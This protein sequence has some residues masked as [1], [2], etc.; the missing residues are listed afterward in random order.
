MRTKEF[1]LLILFSLSYLQAQ[2][3]RIPIYGAVQFEF[4]DSDYDNIIITNISSGEVSTTNII[5][6]FVIK[7]APGD[8]LEAKGVNVYKNETIVTEKHYDRKEILLLLQ[9]LVLQL[10]DLNITGFKF[11]GILEYDVRRVEIKDSLDEAIAKMGIPKG[12]PQDEYKKLTTPVIQSITSLNL[13]ALYDV[14]SGKR[15]KELALYNYKKTL[16][17][18]NEIRSY[19]TDNYFTSSL[20]L[21]AEEIDS[22]ILTILEL[23]NTENAFIHGNFYSVMEIMKQYSPMYLE[24]LKI[25]NRQSLGIGE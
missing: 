8:I 4:T 25:R 10:S 11:S 12:R 24:R 17:T 18:V 9:P 19:Y 2:E 22:F 16:Q 5:G 6:Q 7:A 1:L 20:H 15:K 14:I 23:D 13:D 21:P 3:L